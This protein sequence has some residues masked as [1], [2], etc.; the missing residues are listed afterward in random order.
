MTWVRLAD[1]DDHQVVKHAF[2]RQ[3]HIHDFR[4]REPHQRQED[5]LHGL[6][7]PCVFHG[8]LADYGGGIDR[9]LAMG[10]A[11]NVKDR[12]LIFQ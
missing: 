7:H 8:R 12:V 5:A 9:V 11:R 1:G 6:A 10:D 3:V 4:Q 2:N